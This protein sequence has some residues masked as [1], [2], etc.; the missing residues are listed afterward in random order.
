MLIGAPI[1][2]YII[3]WGAIPYLLFIATITIM[4]LREYFQIVKKGGY[5][6]S[7][8]IGQICGILLL[9]SIYLNGTDLLVYG[10]NQGTAIV[11]SLI[12]LVLF[13]SEFFRAE[14]Q[15][16]L[17]RVGI[18]LLGI[19]LVVWTLGHLILIRDVRPNG[20]MLTYFLFVIIWAVD[21]AAY[22]FGVLLG[23]HRLFPRISPKKTIEGFTGGV[24]CGIS[25]GYIFYLIFLK[26]VFSPVEVLVL[27]LTISVVAQ[28]S[29]LIESL[30]K[31][32]V[33]VKDTSA[34]LPGH[35]GILD[36]F[37]SFIFTAP[38]FFYYISIFQ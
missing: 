28:L 14:I 19:M 26:D 30:I 38:L 18:T 32:S 6:T 35:G 8:V 7:S 34:I 20:M 27:A 15:Y 13:I 2:L 36:R 1:V 23:K 37:D 21:I 12:L 31:R 9:V 33:G 4:G 10:R 24:F 25:C 11:L 3:Y 16:A 5:L 29:D 17:L 22:V